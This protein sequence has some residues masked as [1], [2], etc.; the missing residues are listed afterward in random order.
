[1]TSST[2]SSDGREADGPK[3][4]SPRPCGPYGLMDERGIY[5][6]TWTGERL[7]EQPP[8]ARAHSPLAFNAAVR[9]DP[10]TLIG[11]DSPRLALAI[12]HKGRELSPPWLKL[13]DLR[14]GVE[15]AGDFRWLDEIGVITTTY[16]SWGFQ[17]CIELAPWLPLRVECMA[18]LAEGRALAA[19]VREIPT[20]PLA[21]V[22]IC[23]S[24]GG[25][26]RLNDHRPEYLLPDRRHEEDNVVSLCADHARIVGPTVPFGVVV[27]CNLGMPRLQEAS[28]HPDVE[29][30]VAFTGT[31]AAE[32]LTMC[33]LASSDDSAQLPRLDDFDHCHEDV[34]RYSRQL[35]SPYAIETPETHI[36][37]AF[38][39]AVT[40]LDYSRQG[41]GYLEGVQGWSTYWAINYQISAAVALGR[42][43]EARRALRFAAGG[44]PGE[45][46]FS[47]GSPVDDFYGWQHDALP[48]FVLQL[49]RYW[50][51]TGDDR[52][53]D[54]L[55]SPL[56]M[57]FEGML[58][59][60]DPAGTG[61]L[62][63]HMGCNSFLYQADALQ[64]PGAGFSPSAML[65]CMYRCMADMAERQGQHQ[66]V[67]Q[68]RRAAQYTEHELQ[69]RFW[70][71]AEGR[72]AGCVDGQGLVQT[73]AYYTD[74]VFPVLYTRLPQEY[75]WLSLRAL[76][77]MLW[78]GDDL[79]RVGNF[80]PAG[81]GN[82][83]VQPTQMCE[84]AE[85]YF[86]TGR[87][88]RGLSLLLSSALS[89]TVRTFSPGAFPECCDQEGR[90]EPFYV[91]GNP[92]GAYIQAVVG[93]L[94]GL[95]RAAG[96][97]P[98]AWSPAIPEDWPHARLRLGDVEME[99][100]GRFED[101][102]YSLSLPSDQPA[103][104]SLPLYGRPEVAILNERS[105][106]LTWERVGCPAGDMAVIQLP[107]G[108]R[109]YLRVRLAGQAAAV[110]VQPAANLGSVRCQLPQPGWSVRDPQGVLED[111]RIEGHV[112]EGML[113]AGHGPRAVFLT[114]AVRSRECV[115]ELE[116]PSAPAPAYTPAVA[117]AAG[118]MRRLDVSALLNSDC[119]WEGGRRPV[120]IRF[121]LDEGAPIEGGMRVTVGA[122]TFVVSGKEP[123]F[124]AVEAGYLDWET[125]RLLPSEF[126]DHLDVPVRGH[127]AT[128]QLL[129]GATLKV[130]LTGMRLGQV[131]LRYADGFTGMEP[132]VCGTNVDN[133]RSPFAV[134]TG[135]IR[136]GAGGWLFTLVVPCDPTR[137]LESFTI[138]VVATD[139]Q[140]GLA[141]ANIVEPPEMPERAGDGCE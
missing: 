71:P 12:R 119:L 126:P 95:S 58:R 102:T 16:L 40:N 19:R 39:G 80:R 106:P 50:R 65:V 22:R 127:A 99:I 81:F 60:K 76:D 77:R 61:L 112:L 36:N 116:L 43:D 5:D 74:F 85:A 132:L 64:L 122:T 82:D 129:C 69:R 109:H 114:D 86:R 30:R 41:D 118:R 92:I 3:A 117:P 91:F 27:A 59:R 17:W 67:R 113:A 56:C 104:V 121:T 105:S 24:F 53:V 140:F 18:F 28:A 136:A 37:A 68:W 130:R 44:R 46:L 111:F 70:L 90:G 131:R 13:G 75:A 4:H 78:Q 29:R 10:W 23:L 138:E 98:V 62:T 32:P 101:R 8:K 96:P 38:Y 123:R 141:A 52:L 128:I 55:W 34:Q 66:L 9:R 125:S 48:Y 135:N 115:Y 45:V 42:F 2:E 31:L 20:A 25:V 51:A 110:Q 137:E 84:A 73:A 35:L 94:F 88:D 97:R 14:I 11:G 6:A 83:S 72:F 7:Y 87:A 139:V 1:M 133:S 79:M 33:F 26:C 63:W 107:S 93:G 100:D 108:H 89:A 15:S 134:A 54:E 57:A 103:L 21:E 124:A 47:D 120:P 49:H